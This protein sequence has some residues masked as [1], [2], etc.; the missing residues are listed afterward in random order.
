MWTGFMLRFGAAVIVFVLL[1]VFA[2]CSIS[3]ACGKAEDERSKW[4]E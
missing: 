1:I 2:C 4:N 3:S